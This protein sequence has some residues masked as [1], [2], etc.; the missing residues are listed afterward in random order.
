[1]L[2]QS[3]DHSTNLSGV[4]AVWCGRRDEESVAN[5]VFNNT[6]IFLNLVFYLEHNMPITVFQKNSQTI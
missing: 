1:M 2:R 3:R 6:T 5:A 4:T